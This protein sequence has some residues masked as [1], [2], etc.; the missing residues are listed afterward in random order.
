MSVIQSGCK[1]SE[2]CVIGR[3]FNPP[4]MIPFVEV[5]GDNRTKPEAIQQAISFYILTGKN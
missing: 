4:H 2:R 3:P 5:V 1:R